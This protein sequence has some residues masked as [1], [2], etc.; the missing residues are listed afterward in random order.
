MHTCYRPASCH[1]L[2]LKCARHKSSK[3]QS[4]KVH[5]QMTPDRS[6]RSYTH[7]IETKSQPSHK[8]RACKY[9]IRPKRNSAPNNN[10][11]TASNS[12]AHTACRAIRPVEIATR[13]PSA[14]SARTSDISEKA[15]TAAPKPIFFAYVA[16]TKP[17]GVKADRVHAADIAAILAN[18][19][20]WCSRDLAKSG[21]ERYLEQRCH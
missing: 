9:N 21:G 15:T 4:D 5:H 19:L 13:R 6:N 18:H 16:W 11:N 2:L 10:Y 14:L 17:T 1:C 3:C 7:I 20:P 8:R 12:D